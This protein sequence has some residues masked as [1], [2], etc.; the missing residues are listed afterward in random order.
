MRD[1]ST[2]FPAFCA[3]RCNFA[4][5]L[6]CTARFS[7]RVKKRK[8]FRPQKRS[9]GNRS[10]SVLRCVVASLLVASRC[11]RPLHLD[12]NRWSSVH[13]PYFRK[14]QHCPTPHA[15]TSRIPIKWFYSKNNNF[16]FVT[17]NW[18]KCRVYIHLLDRR[19]LFKIYL[20]SFREKMQI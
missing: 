1:D 13:I 18:N 7:S 11:L 20:F 2:R 5:F 4:I 6:Q 3:R 15:Y 19:V 12:A 10:A 9:G 14:K 16:S 8:E 17:Y